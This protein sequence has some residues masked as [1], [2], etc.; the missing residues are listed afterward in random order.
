MKTTTTEQQTPIHASIEGLR[1]LAMRSHAWSSFNPERRGRQI[2][3]EYSEQLT[4]D[5]ELIAKHEGDNQRYVT[6]Y[7]SLLSDWLSAKSRCASS[8]IT[9]PA[10]FPVE[11]N[12]KAMN[13][14]QNKYESF[15]T[16]RKKALHAITKPENTDIVK[17]TE[18]A[19]DK[20]RTKLEGLEKLQS[21]MKD[22]NKILKS[23]KT[24]KAEKIEIFTEKY[25]KINIL[26]LLKPDFAGQTGFAGFYLTNNN[27]KINNLKKDIIAEQRR[28]EKYAEGNKE[29]KFE[30]LTIIENVDENRLQLIF[31]DKPDYNTRAKLKSYGLRWSPKNTAW[32]RQL[33]NNAV[34]SIKLLIK[35]LYPPAN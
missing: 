28:A 35:E 30:G 5:L 7:V 6:K 32:Q 2:L 15:T 26:E 8:M 17:G 14:E 9:G 29:H 27:A 25:P 12:R 19:I 10:N 34:Y 31:D 20:M 4:E 3:T 22:M 11:R 1:S 13:S 16:W 33:T 18:G 24:T 21:S 23:K